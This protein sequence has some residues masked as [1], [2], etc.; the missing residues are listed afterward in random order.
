[1]RLAEAPSYGKP[2]ILYDPK[3]RG[4]ESYRDLADELLSRHK[5]QSPRAKERQTAAASNRNTKVRFW[6]YG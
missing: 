1:V 3:S 2:V 4:S 5:I 6:P